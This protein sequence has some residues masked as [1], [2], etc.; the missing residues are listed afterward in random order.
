MYEELG[1]FD[2]YCHRFRGINAVGNVRQP[3]EL[4][5]RRVEVKNL[6]SARYDD[7]VLLDYVSSLARLRCSDGW[8]LLERN[9]EIWCRRLP[10][11]LEIWEKRGIE[12]LSVKIFKG[13]SQ[14][15]LIKAE[16]LGSQ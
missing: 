8:L 10:D 15:F 3:S 16:K 4:L 13:M 6:F 7:M 1:A 12:S 11:D 14:G 5:Q 2:R 9:H